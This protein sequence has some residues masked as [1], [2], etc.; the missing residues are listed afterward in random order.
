MTRADDRRQ[1]LLRRLC[2]VHIFAPDRVPDTTPGDFAELLA[3]DLDR[4][5]ISDDD[6][7]LYAM[8]TDVRLDILDS[9]DTA[10]EVLATRGA[11]V[12]EPTRRQKVLDWWLRA[13]QELQRGVD[14]DALAASLPTGT[15]P[16]EAARVLFW[17]RRVRFARDL[18]ADMEAALA[19]SRKREALRRLDEG[20]TGFVG[21][22]TDLATL[23]AFVS[24]E[25][26][27]LFLLDAVGGMGKSALLSQFE[28]QLARRRPTWVV[29]HLDFDSARIDIRSAASVFARVLELLAVHVPPLGREAASL[30][31]DAFRDILGTST[32]SETRAKLDANLKD[33]LANSKSILDRARADVQRVVVVLDTIERALRQSVDSVHAILRDLLA[34][35]AET[36]VRII[37]SGRGVSGPSHLPVWPLPIEAYRLPELDENA[38]LG[39]LAQSVSPALAERL[40]RLVPWRPLTLRLAARASELHDEMNI[41]ELRAAVDRQLADGYLHLRILRRIDPNLAP[42]LQRAFLLREIT[43][44]L[45]LD[46]L[47]AFAIPT[48]VDLPAA[49]KLFGRIRS[50]HDL[51][52]AEHDKG[53]DVVMLRPELRTELL[54]LVRKD[55]IETAMEL[56][57]RWWKYFQRGQQPR[58][59]LFHFLMQQ[60]DARVELVE[61][62]VSRLDDMAAATE[63]DRE[64]GRVARPA[65]SEI[66]RRFELLLADGK[67]EEADQLTRT[68]EY[69]AQRDDLL[70]FEAKL[71]RLQ[72]RVADAEDAARRA[73]AHTGDGAP[74]LELICIQAW[75]AAQ[76]GERPDPLVARG[77]KQMSTHTG[78]VLLEPHEELSAC[79]DLAMIAPE[80]R[81]AEVRTRI[82]DLLARVGDARLSQDRP[83]LLAAALA[84]GDPTQLRRALQLKALDDFND[85]PRAW[86]HAIISVPFTRLRASIGSV[87]LEGYNLTKPRSRGRD[88]ASPLGS[89]L[90]L[91]DPDADDLVRR[92]LTEAHRATTTFVAG[93]TEERARARSELTQHIESYVPSTLRGEIAA[94][95]GGSVQESYRSSD[96][97]AGWLTTVA[98]QDGALIELIDSL[99]E[100]DP[101]PDRIERLARL[102]RR[103]A[104][105]AVFEWNPFEALLEV[106]KQIADSRVE[107][108]LDACGVPWIRAWS[109]HPKVRLLELLELVNRRAD[110]PYPTILQNVLPIRRVATLPLATELPFTS[111]IPTDN[112]WVLEGGRPFVNRRNLRSCI[113]RLVNA[114][115]ETVLLINGPPGSGKSYS[116]HLIRHTAIQ[117]GFTVLSFEVDAL[118]TAEDLALEIHDRLGERVEV[119]S[120]ALE[121]AERTGARYASIVAQTLQTR[122]RRALLIFDGFAD[123]TPRDVSSFVIRLARS[124]DEEARPWLRIVLIGFLGSLPDSLR[125][126]ALVDN[127][128]PFTR[129]DVRVFLER[130]AVQEGWNVAHDALDELADSIDE[131]STLRDKMLAVRAVLGDLQQAASP[132]SAPT[133]IARFSLDEAGTPRR[134][135]PSRKAELHYIVILQIERA[136]GALASVTYKLDDTFIE[137]VREVDQPPRFLEEVWTYGDFDIIATLHWSNGREARIA[138]PL[139]EMLRDGHRADMRP[140]IEAAIENLRRRG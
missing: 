97:S 124:S 68:A 11:L 140:A 52:E 41:A 2:A 6:R 35:F 83:T 23:D 117:H 123:P 80:V 27:K 126:I 10:T 15:P 47:G 102:R 37:A 104:K 110:V 26:G 60:R 87:N 58:E 139:V 107:Q 138:R 70:R 116:A 66:E 119:P 113:R 64:L 74:M 134:E 29:V 128:A 86:F 69:A 53:S 90:L 7:E 85:V 84:S 131:R 93:R 78:S 44:Q 125:D 105:P 50:L 136:P 133:L 45:I 55:D 94:E 5:E 8:R 73:E 56:H 89:L 114:S 19:R 46:L 115:G 91:T 24:G 135:R 127:I 51:V 49:Q 62:R 130:V 3:R 18:A 100:R 42:L 120:T 79:A 99:L 137:P 96:S 13:V 36:E 31:R 72:G 82:N 12:G 16:D 132:Q 33:I 39:L 61:E 71:H 59:A 28:L 98:D 111:S 40:L 122:K 4:V 20:A 21:R 65:K 77:L 9:F 81:R 43:P 118:R 129:D 121:T 14:V 112:P 17:F 63:L 25:P 1:D 103:I 38:A 106:W 30:A 22:A 109:Q 67:L 34:L 57:G 48:V 32:S 92:V 101:R 75:A 108:L 76:R 95:L 88:L 54:R